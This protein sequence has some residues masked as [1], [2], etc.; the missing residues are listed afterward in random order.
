M[1]RT[2]VFSAF[3]G[4]TLLA[5]LPLLA[6]I[7]NV[8]AVNQQMAG[9][10]PDSERRDL[11]IGNDII[12]N[13]RIE[14]S[15][16][17]SGQ[18]LFIDQ[19]SLTISQNS[20]LVLDKYVFDPDAN[21]GDIAM[22]MTRGAL[23]FIGG[24]ITK[25]RRALV[26]T[27]T[28][29]IGIRGG[30]ALIKIGANG[31]VS[32]THL[33]GEQTTVTSFGDA[34]GDGVDDG[35]S[36]G[37]LEGFLEGE[38]PSS[39]DTV[40]LS[41]PS[42]TATA[43][44]TGTGDGAPNRGR[45]QVTFAGLTSAEELQESY[46]N[47]EGGQS[48]G[49][50][51]P[52]TDEAVE[53]GTGQVAN[54]NSNVPRRHRE[55]P[56]STGGERF[57]EEKSPDQSPDNPRSQTPPADESQ[58]R[59]VRENPPPGSEPQPP[60]PQPPEPQPPEP[61]PPEPQPPEPQ[62]PE[63]PAALPEGGFLFV[64]GAGFETFVDIREGSLIGETA[65]GDTITL[66]VPES[67]A[68]FLPTGGASG[69]PTPFA[70][71]RFPNSGFFEIAFGDAVS[72]TEGPLQGIGFAD[73]D[74]NLIFAPLLTQQQELLLVFFGTPTPDNL[75]VQPTV[76]SFG[77]N[78][79]VVTRFAVEPF[80]VV[81]DNDLVDARF[82]IVQNGGNDASQGFRGLFG[83]LNIDAAGNEDLTI[84]AAPLV[85][86]PNGP[87]LS[88]TGLSSANETFGNT[89]EIRFGFFNLG[90][91]E[92]AEGHTVFGPNNDYVVVTS[93]FRDN[94]GT[95]PFVT[96]DP[97]EEIVISNGNTDVF[98]ELPT[99]AVLTRDPNGFEVITNPLPL[100]NQSGTAVPAA[101]S[102]ILNVFATGIASCGSRP[103]GFGASLPQE[104]NTYALTPFFV[105]PEALPLSTIDFGGTNQTDNSFTASF[106]LT[107]GFESNLI[108]GPEGP[109]LFVLAT[110]PEE[111]TAISDRVFGSAT[112][113]ADISVIAGQTNEELDFALGSSGLVGD[114]GILPAGVD[115]EPD[116]VRWGFWS[117]TYTGTDQF[118]NV[119]TQDIVHL[120]TFVGGVLPDPDAFA[121]FNGTATFNG[122]AAG[123]VANLQ[124][125]RS[126]TIGGSFALNYN[127]G[128]GQGNLN[129]NL[130]AANFN[131][132][133][134]VFRNGPATVPTYSGGIEN[135]NLQ[136]QVNGAFFA[137]GND[138]AA[139]TG[140]NFD[141]LDFAQD[142]RAVGVFAGDK[143]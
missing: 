6:E 26:R 50:R 139:G 23:R 93:A 44:R 49:S 124:T 67:S 14:T 65:S 126:Q 43:E 60:E 30:M 28:A 31:Q 75:R 9:T 24:K 90:T 58:D 35:P 71:S 64:P 134:Q 22:T 99:G 110:N 82:A 108:G 94:N 122:L 78:V 19:T 109:D 5:P 70:Q 27:P 57:V 97:G 29:T 113:G 143:N 84:I 21:Q 45:A 132:N 72:S 2:T 16:L 77:P 63:P 142:Q 15:E 133:I 130:P 39:G 141:I 7:G 10:R 79:N 135:S 66:P 4:M 46:N 137:G 96:D 11:D 3:L 95:G 117:A 125:G 13:E 32:V 53:R 121:A 59:I 40:T 87:I 136:A 55:R 115:P 92:D 34:N 62:P 103:C 98:E 54:V 36:E 51:T 81:I 25:K 105:G 116:F 86:T 20:D 129:L 52:V 102:G 101:S 76:T 8:A 61:Q 48:G 118:L 33:A 37:E 91:G 104:T 38:P 83:E 68:D 80:D 119:P 127:F 128:A 1:M 12:Q 138:P 111:S 123:T 73:L 112:S 88:T 120:G 100:V 47:F 56:V 17:G 131:E 69:L 140:G 74:N 107:D 85:N 114:G 42:S 106:A 89:R 18:L 41:R